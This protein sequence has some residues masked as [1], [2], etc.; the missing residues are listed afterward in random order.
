[1]KLDPRTIVKNAIVALTLGLAGVAS[2]ALTTDFAAP[3]LQ[4][5][6]MLTQNR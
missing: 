5:E 3:T 6:F 4:A 2:W 1:M